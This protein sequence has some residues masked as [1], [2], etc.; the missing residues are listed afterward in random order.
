MYLNI[1]QPKQQKEN[2]TTN[3]KKYL[4]YIWQNNDFVNTEN[5]PTIL[6]TSKKKTIKDV[7]KCIKDIIRVNR[8][9]KYK[10]IFYI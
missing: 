2:Q 9:R 8:K 4:R 7:V 5:I 3:W 10:R 6:Q 1:T